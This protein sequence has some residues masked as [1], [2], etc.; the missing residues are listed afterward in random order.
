MVAFAGYPLLVGDRLLGV[1]ALFAKE[2]LSADSLSTLSSVANQIALGIERDN[3]ERFRE[4]FMG[5]LGHDLRSPLNA[6]TM[7]TE[8]LAADPALAAGQARMVERIRASAWRMGRMITQVLDFTQARAGGG[9]S[10]AREPADLHAICAQ[11][12]D[13]LATANPARIIETEY[14]GEAHGEWDADRLARVFTNLVGNALKHGRQD[15]PV[16]VEVD[17]TGAAVRCL[18]GNLGAPISGALLPN[19]FDPFRQGHAIR[20]GSADGLG[21]GLF[22]AQQIVVAHGGRIGVRSSAEDG[23]QF[24]FDLS[25]Q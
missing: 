2:E 6:I 14:S 15:A 7:G 17:A 20:S 11:A 8:L 19:L 3:N 25:R 9:I 24:S 13:E 21:L 10:I 12:V 5:I 23:T 18:V 4:L 16:R 1:M 22:I